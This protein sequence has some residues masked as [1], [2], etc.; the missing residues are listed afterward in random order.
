[1]SE[2]PLWQYSATQLL[3]L[4]Q[5]GEVSSQEVVES[6]IQRIEAV[7][8]QLNS[9]AIP[10]FEQA[11][12]EA[13]LADLHRQQH[14]PQG[15]LFGLPMSIKEQ[16]HVQ[17]TDVTMGLKRHQGKPSPQDGP[18]VR[19]LRQAGAIVLGKT[20]VMQLLFGYETDNPVYGRSLNPFDPER[21]PGGSSGGEAALI[22]A[23][24]S[25][26]GL[27][28]DLG[29]SIRIPAHFCGIH[30]FKTTNWRFTISDTPGHLLGAGQTVIIPTIGPMARHVDDLRLCL[31]V[32][33]QPLPQLPSDLHPPMR[34]KSGD[35]KALSELRIGWIE[36]DGFFPASPA[37]RRVVREGAQA[38]KDRGLQ[39][40]P[41]VIPQPKRAIQMFYRAL[42]MD[43]GAA[44][45][46]S[47]GNEK[48]IKSLRMLLLGA[49]APGFARW[50]FEQA[51]RLQ[52][53]HRFADTVK[54]LRKGSAREYF[55]LVWEIFAYRNLFLQKMKESEV[56]I[57]LCPP[58]ALPAPRH[59]TSDDVAHAASYAQLFNLL[60]MPAGVLAASRVREGEESDRP[61]SR[62]SMEQAAARNEEGSAGLP[63]GLQVVGRHWQEQQVLLV[64]KALEE[65]FEQQKDYP[66]GMAF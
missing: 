26:L 51:A 37:L 11:R 34:W 60:G 31:E 63:V 28:A 62:D 18:M 32:M 4:I 29:G 53:N 1:M 8:G 38:L 14:K 16:F 27:G 43:G 19:Q 3:Q 36:D 24:G 15:A 59:G 52:G 6:H 57:L 23:G 65:H 50:L 41:F 20:N 55:Q 33:A 66:V 13:R 54:N 10:L 30:G 39:V 44:L 61:A 45:R 5:S 9:L 46:E 7:D 12:E 56:D 22:A 58:F 25:P 47:V 40:R 35:P 42:M 21:T 48:V 2:K 17:G 64:M 49:K